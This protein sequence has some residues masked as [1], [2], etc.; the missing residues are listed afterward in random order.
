M[1]KFIFTKN[2]SQER[3]RGITNSSY[4]SLPYGSEITYEP[5][6]NP[7][8]FYYFTSSQN[9][10]EDEFRKFKSLK[11]IINK[12]K[13]LDEIFDFSNLE[14]TDLTLIS[15]NSYNLGSGIKKGS[16]A[17]NFL[18]TGSVLTTAA[19]I[20]ENGIL[21]DS[22][23]TKVGFVLYNEGFVVLTGSESLSPFTTEWN[24]Y[25]ST[26]P[27]WF[28]FGALSSSNIN[29]SCEMNYEV[30]NEVPTKTIFIEANKNLFNHSNNSTYI[31][32]SSYVLPTTS[33]NS[34]KENAQTAIAKTNKSPFVSGSAT[35]EKQTFIT[36]I[37][38]YDEDKNLI[39]IANLS[40]PV[41]KTENR[42]FLFKL[43][44]DI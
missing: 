28:L 14:T 31:L 4:N 25:G 40:N 43:K 9:R 8:T 19:D 44:L 24:G 34:F 1:S 33:S 23:N 2:G 11:N 5:T 18:Y 29:F 3:P 32:S 35:F 21:Y 36:T 22:S 6:N 38:L 7:I 27:R 12:H 13:A 10:V 26:N 20:L 41:R 30:K 39:G 17:L 37:G 42:E 15:L 16:V